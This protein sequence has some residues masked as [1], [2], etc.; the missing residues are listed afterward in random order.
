MSKT[1]YKCKT[2]LNCLKLTAK[3]RI[4]VLDFGLNFGSTYSQFCGVFKELTTVFVIF[5]Y[6]SVPCTPFCTFICNTVGSESENYISQI[7][8]LADFL[9][10]SATGRHT[11]EI[12][13]GQRRGEGILFLLTPSLDCC[14]SGTF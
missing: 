3:S 13:R 9:L 8:L 11:W 2:E 5:Y 7:P 14:D 4:L 6:L 10:G 12:G 1:E